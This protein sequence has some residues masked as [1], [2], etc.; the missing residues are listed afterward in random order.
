MRISTCKLSSWTKW[1]IRVDGTIARVLAES[2]HKLARVILTRSRGQTSNWFCKYAPRLQS[3][4]DQSP[5]A[6]IWWLIST[7]SRR[8]W[9]RVANSELDFRRLSL[10]PW[11]QHKVGGETFGQQKSIFFLGWRG[12]LVW[13]ASQHRRS[14]WKRKNCK[15]QSLREGI[16]QAEVSRLSF[17]DRLSSK[18]AI[19]RTRKA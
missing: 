5:W 10:E 17:K 9:A 16:K 11:Q 1:L 19:K 12:V 8:T 7:N 13:W 4:L 3:W 15:T 6:S 14:K 18:I 2:A